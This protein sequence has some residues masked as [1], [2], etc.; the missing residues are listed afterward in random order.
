MFRGS[1]S[2]F[3]LRKSGNQ[4]RYPLCS[5]RCRNAPAPAQATVQPSPR[6]TRLQ[7]HE[8]KTLLKTNRITFPSHSVTNTLCRHRK[9]T[10]RGLNGRVPFSFPVSFRKY[11]CVYEG[12]SHRCIQTAL[13]DGSHRPRGSGTGRPQPRTARPFPRTAPLQRGAGPARPASPAPGLTVRC[14]PR[15]AAMSAGAPRWCVF[16]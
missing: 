14:C 12:F 15:A 3:A 13:M 5:S 4:A 7:R 1:G 10:V 8:H 2:R 11:T 16:L 6:N 9:G